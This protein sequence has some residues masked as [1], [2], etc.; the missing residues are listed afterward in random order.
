M[1][2]APHELPEEFPGQTGR[3]HALKLA[4]GRF[5][6]LVERYHRV[7]RALHRMEERIEPVSEETEREFRR[8]R[9]RL[10]DEIARALE[11]AAV[12]A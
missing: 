11:I 9:L 4:D 10:K 2:H 6:S 7:N 12:A 3:I 8:E 1:S 5:A